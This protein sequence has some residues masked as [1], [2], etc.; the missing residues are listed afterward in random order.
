MT[1]GGQWLWVHTALLEGPDGRETAAFVIDERT[2]PD[3]ET[4]RA[5]VREAFDALQIRG[6]AAQFETV[7]VSPHEPAPPLPSWAEYRLGLDGERPHPPRPRTLLRVELSGDL[8]RDRLD[9]LQAGLGMRRSGRLSQDWSD[10]FGERI[11][12]GEGDSQTSMRLR[13]RS[14]LAWTVTVSA[15]GA[16]PSGAEVEQWRD[17][18]LAAA[19]GAG[20]VVGEVEV[21]S[22]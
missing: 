7:L 22:F 2:Y 18:V 12:A 8:D 21:G 14:P 4:A 17:E 15:R 19:A 13:R 16:A 6:I 10:S 20:L 1:D 11:L 9:R 5:A 3:Q